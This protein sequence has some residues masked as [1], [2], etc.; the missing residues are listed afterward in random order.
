MS[1]IPTMT[2]HEVRGCRIPDEEPGFGALATQKGNLPLEA[3]DVQ[4]SIT[5]LVSEVRLSQTFVNGFTE[6][7]EATYLFPMPDRAAVTKFVMTVN[8]R[9]IV[10]ILKER[11]EARRDYDVAIQAGHR[12][13]IAEEERPN[14]FT[15]RVGNL[16]PGEKATIHLVMTSPLPYQ[17]GEATFRFPLVVAPRY[18]PGSA[19]GGVP[20]G[21]GTAEDTDAVPDASRITA[22]VLLPGFPNPVRLG[23]TVDVDPA[24]LPFKGMKSSLHA[25]SAET[26]GK[27]TRVSIQP[28]ER[29][30]R[31]FILRLALGEDAIRTSLSLKA[32]EGKE[33]PAAGTFVLTLVPPVDVSKATKPRDVVFVLDHSGSMGGWKMVASRRAVA[34]MVDTL[35]DKD[36]FT[37]YAFDD[38]ID[39]VPAFGGTGLVAATDR[40]RFRAVEFLAKVEADGGTEMAAPLDLAAKTLQAQPEAEGRRGGSGG[41]APGNHMRERQRILVLVT[42]GQVGNE[43]QILR[44]L[45]PQINGMRIFTVGIDSA[46][47]DGF[48]KR[49]AGIGGGSCELV[50]GEDRLDEVMDK[51]HRRIGTPV[52]TEVK[53]EADGLTIEGGTVT[54]TRMPALFAGAPLVIAGRFRGKATGGL[55]ITGVDS[56]GRPWSQH[57]KPGESANP[58]VATVWA[59]AHVRELED[60]YVIHADAKLEKRIVETSLFFG[61]LCR[62]TA[63]VAVDSSEVVNKGGKNRK[64]TQ[65]L[66]APA[67][68]DMFG[69]EAEKDAKETVRR[70]NSAGSATGM[71]ANKIASRSRSASG[72]MASAPPPPPMEADLEEM[73]DAGAMAPPATKAK[74]G[75]GILNNL[76]GKKG[77]RAQAPAPASKKPAP[78]G[79]M[80]TRQEERSSES[81]VPALDLGSYR[82]RAR[83]ILALLEATE[84]SVHLLR[85][86]EAAVKLAALVEDLTSVGA[87][88]NEVKPLSELL[89]SLK[90]GLAKTH[91]DAAAA[92]VLVEA[93]VKALSTFGN[94]SSGATAPTPPRRE[95]F[96]K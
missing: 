27:S 32:D 72:P 64:M 55:V 20:V 81:G 60:Q 59:R 51:I 71:S 9:E 3:V 39:T 67:G 62:F 88:A 38:S 41:E 75:G 46:V 28:N 63:F 96:W 16:M 35:G 15:M 8:G 11:G 23:I 70:G 31:D 56:A 94:G 58:A 77:S 36:R 91:L 74:S 24:G 48:L 82:E 52:L 18:I 1:A 12:A 30:D 79:R 44:M 10:G 69:G 83:E 13:A 54:P 87:P 95:G 86:G 19:L 57:V 89:A 42:D 14:T 65:P 80:S 50:E 4:V 76:F 68:W 25:I 53:V 29:L 34:R 85:L 43:D 93:S 47:N 33:L 66:D 21:D 37:V 6:P 73:D 26:K 84:A 2:D 92:A 17:D 5:G 45:G 61:V 78:V 7:L 90:K 22:P 40:N 49:L